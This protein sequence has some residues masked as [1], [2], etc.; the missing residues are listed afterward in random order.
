[1]KCNREDC[2]RR[3]TRWVRLRSEFVD[4]T[5]PFCETCAR[6]VCAAKPAGKMQGTDVGAIEPR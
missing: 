5:R 2:Q 4:M 6:D 1:M 3:A